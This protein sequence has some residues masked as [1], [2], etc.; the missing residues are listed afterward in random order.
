MS[1][2]VDSPSRVARATTPRHVRL[3]S[4]DN[5]GQVGVEAEAWIR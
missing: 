5:L 4:T 3:W 1:E 2:L